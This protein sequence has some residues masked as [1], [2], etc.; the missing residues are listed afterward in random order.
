MPCQVSAVIDKAK[1]QYGRVDS[2]ASCV[3][4]M[5][6]KPAHLTS[7]EEFMECIKLNTF[8]SFNV[9]KAAVCPVRMCCLPKMQP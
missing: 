6:I 5:L 8:S 2:V 7:T 1:Q 9:L 4:N 3:G